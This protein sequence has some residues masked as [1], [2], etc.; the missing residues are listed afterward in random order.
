M[1]SITL[2]LPY[3]V[4]CNRYWRHARG[5]TFRSKE[6]DAY[7]GAVRLAALGAEPKSGPVEVVLWLHPRTTRNGEAS[8]T[9]MDIDNCIKVTLDALNGIAYGDDRQVVRLIA[10]VKEPMPAGGL[11]V[12]VTSMEAV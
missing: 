3:P 5:M 2:T 12:S 8:K 11:S 6:A 10:E 9:R 7:R 1:G 4:S